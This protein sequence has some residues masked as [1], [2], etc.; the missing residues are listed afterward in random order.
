MGQELGRL[1][2]TRGQKWCSTGT[3]DHQ[4]RT[5][6]WSLRLP[7]LFSRLLILWKH[8]GTTASLP[9]SP[10]PDLSDL[11]LVAVAAAAAA[12]VLFVLVDRGNDDADDGGGGG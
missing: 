12:V 4:R 3:G 11:P 2:T 5:N 10:F 8:R 9:Q 7:A 6:E 1:T